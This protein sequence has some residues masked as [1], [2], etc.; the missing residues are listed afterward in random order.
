MDVLDF[1]KYNFYIWASYLI[2][3]LVLLFN[4][5]LPLLSKKKILTSLK[6]RNYL[7]N[8]ESNNTADNNHE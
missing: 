1:G 6:R 3:F 4:I 8:I 7:S 5:V 2:T